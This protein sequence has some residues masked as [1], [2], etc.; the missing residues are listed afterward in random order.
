MFEERLDVR[1]ATVVI[2][3]LY[4]AKLFLSSQLWV[5]DKT[6]LDLEFVRRVE[7]VVAGIH[8]MAQL[9][10][11]TEMCDVILFQPLLEF[12]TGPTFLI[13]CEK[14]VAK[15]KHI[16]AKC[17]LKPCKSACSTTT[18]MRIRSRATFFLELKREFRLERSSKV[19]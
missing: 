7:R 10:R 5:I 2:R 9:W 4:D 6:L 15:D 18:K 3:S 19:I 16:L 1:F 8:E 14:H 11:E 12:R 17:P 13:I